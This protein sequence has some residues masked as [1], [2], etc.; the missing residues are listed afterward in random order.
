MTRCRVCSTP[1]P[2][3]GSLGGRPRRRCR[4]CARWAD[5]LRVQRARRKERARR[6]DSLTPK[7]WDL[8]HLTPEFA[9]A[10]ARDGLVVADDAPDPDEEDAR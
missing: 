6:I 3:P 8:L 2:P 1:L 10:V 9:A 5:A 4:P 7:E